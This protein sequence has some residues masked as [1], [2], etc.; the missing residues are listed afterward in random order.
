MTRVL[1]TG[2]TGSLGSALTRRL[3]DLGLD[4]RVLVLPAG[5]LGGLR[6]RAGEFE[7]VRGDVTVP[8]GLDRAM[9]GVEFVFHLAGEATLLNR[10]R[11]RM[12]AVNVGGARAV[13]EAA[14]RAGVRRLVHTS[15]VSA[16]GYPPAGEVADE[17]FDL[18][19]SALRNAYLDTKHAGERAVLRVGERTGL[20]VV[21]VNPAAVLAPY[22]HRRHGWAALVQ[23]A[24]RGRLAAWP[25]GGLAVCATADLVSGELAALDRG[26]PG[27]RYIL[28]TANL[29]YRELFTL[30]CRTV[31]AAEPRLAVPAPVVR[32]AGRV[33]AL[34]ALATRDP[35]RSP[36]LVPENAALA[37]RQIFY[38]PALSRR[39]LGVRPTPVAASVA[40]VAEWLGRE[41][42]AFARR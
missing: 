14:A 2:G 39:E 33:G 42:S 8:A 29:S 3:L 19:R 32:A 7:V 5:D 37:V 41:D 31:G 24:M 21:V 1:V 12:A 10:L 15:S 38:D 4:V 9:A 26:R 30:V 18:R 40:E 22:S 34:R 20:E 27:A 35:M 25:P 11:P 13:G 16:I 23:Q 17:S 36:V 28:S 6:G